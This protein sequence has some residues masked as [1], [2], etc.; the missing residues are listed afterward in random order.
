MEQKTIIMKS[1]D[2]VLVR[3]TGTVLLGDNNY[4]TIHYELWNSYEKFKGNIQE[5][6]INGEQF[7]YCFN[8][9]TTSEEN[10]IEDFKNMIE[11]MS[12]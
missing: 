2:G 12:K 9:A 1:K 7:I 8:Y 3:V 11:R 10:A 4:E 6:R 5:E